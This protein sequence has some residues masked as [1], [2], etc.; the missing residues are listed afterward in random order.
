MSYTYSYIIGTETTYNTVFSVRV[1]SEPTTPVSPSFMDKI[2]ICY[3]CKFH[4]RYS[5]EYLQ[6]VITMIPAKMNYGVRAPP[7]YWC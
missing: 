7:Y 6:M 4:E 1:K 3:P 5:N 2:V